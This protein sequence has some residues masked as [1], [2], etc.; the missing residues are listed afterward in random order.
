M[1]SPSSIASGGPG[2]ATKAKRTPSM[3]IA[4]SGPSSSRPGERR[5]NEAI[6]SLPRDRLLGQPDAVRGPVHHFAVKIGVTAR[7]VVGPV[8]VAKQG[9]GWERGHAPLLAC[10]NA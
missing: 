7:P 10:G 1:K 6:E 8:F 9:K 2:L 5:K 3:S 4:S